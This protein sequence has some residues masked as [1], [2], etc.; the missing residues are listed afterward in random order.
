MSDQAAQPGLP[1]PTAPWARAWS[2]LADQALVWTIFVLAAI[3]NRVA[4]LDTGV[5]GA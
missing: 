4:L 5:A 1:L 2:C 3:L